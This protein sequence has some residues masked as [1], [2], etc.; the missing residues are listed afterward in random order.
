MQKFRADMQKFRADMQYVRSDM[1]CFSRASQDKHAVSEV[2][3][4]L[5]TGMHGNLNGFLEENT[6]HYNR[7]C[8]WAISGGNSHDSSNYLQ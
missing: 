4:H 6:L 7:I 3:T 5:D 8:L 2:L 1:Q